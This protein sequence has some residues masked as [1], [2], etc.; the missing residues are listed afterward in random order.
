MIISLVP[1]A[2]F[3]FVLLSKIG[4]LRDT[5]PKSAGAG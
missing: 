1:G 2:Q 3:W 5:G 4:S